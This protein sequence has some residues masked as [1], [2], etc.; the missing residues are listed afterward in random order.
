MNRLFFGAA[1]FL[2]VMISFNA[3][4][5]EYPEMKNMKEFHSEIC[6]GHE[7][8]ALCE[9][10]V[11]IMMKSV[12]QNDDIYIQCL[13]LSPSQR[14]NEEGCRSAQAIRQMISAFN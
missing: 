9:R 10:V 6:K 11:G 13:K 12:M 7:K 2:S 8:P 1:F 5:D 4:A 3:N 14:E